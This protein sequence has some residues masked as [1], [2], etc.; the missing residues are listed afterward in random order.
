MK[1]LM[2]R[3]D[4]GQ[5]NKLF[6]N[7]NVII[8]LH[9]V[10]MF[11]FRKVTVDVYECKTSLYYVLYAICKNTK[12]PTHGKYICIYIYILLFFFRVIFH[13]GSEY[14]YVLHAYTLATYTTFEMGLSGFKERSRSNVKTSYFIIPI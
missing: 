10:T 2:S 4:E 5:K 13:K 3:S 7:S 9:Y 14:K 1:T 12:W 6:Q 11:V 8:Y